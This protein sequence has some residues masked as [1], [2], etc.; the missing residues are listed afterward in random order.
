M[1]ASKPPFI[2]PSSFVD[3][4][5]TIGDDTKVW[6]FCHIMPGAVIGRGC[7][8]GQNVVVMP[9]TRIGDNCKIQNNVSIYEGVVLEDDVFCGP[10]MV[11]TNVLNPRSHVSR[12]HEY[13]ETLVRRGATIGANATVVCGTTLG[14]YAFVG[15]GAVVTHDV[16]PFA[17]VTG[18]PAR[19]V[20][21]MC[22][23]GERLD[24]RDTNSEIRDIRDQRS[25]GA[26]ARS[27]VRTETPRVTC[28]V[29]G[30]AYVL[31]EGD[32]RIEENG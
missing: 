20:G 6:H 4:G 25:A 28:E 26:A 18:V 22:R 15:A 31:E 12:K 9:R 32:L 11:F 30:T 13:R 24:I 29:C 14:E 19:Q 23:C 1:A 16:K 21:W 3:D 8:L 7:S 2:H 5:A 17:L 27:V 10:S